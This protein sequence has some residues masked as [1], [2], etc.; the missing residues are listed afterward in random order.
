MTQILSDYVSAAA[1]VGR[2]PQTLE[3]KRAAAIAWLGE[4]WVLH[5]K[6]APRKGRYHYG[7]AKRGR[8]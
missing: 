6:N 5:P 7:E 1:R 2:I 8:A 4:R 3:E